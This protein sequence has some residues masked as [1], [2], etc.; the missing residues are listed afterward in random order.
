VAAGVMAAVSIA[1]IPRFPDWV[2]TCTSDGEF[3]FPTIADQIARVKPPKEHGYVAV[4]SVG[5][6]LVM[7]KPGIKG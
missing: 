3:T 2:L 7:H 1:L 4:Y 5:G 6:C